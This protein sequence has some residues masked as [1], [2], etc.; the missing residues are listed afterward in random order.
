MRKANNLLAYIAI[1]G[2]VGSVGCSANGVQVPAIPDSVSMEE[3]CKLSNQIRCAGAM[4]C[5]TERANGYANQEACESARLCESSLGLIFSSNE[6]TTGVIR[7]DGVKAAESLKQQAEYT[8]VCGATNLIGNSPSFIVGTKASGA[9]C[10]AKKDDVVS[11][12]TCQPGLTCAVADPEAFSDA[13][14]C[15]AARAVAAGGRSYGEACADS[16]ECR[17]GIC[18]NGV[19]STDTNSSFCVRVADKMLPAN[20]IS[21]LYPTKIRITPK[22]EQSG[23]DEYGDPK[24]VAGNSGT[25][26]RI[27]VHLIIREAYTGVMKRYYG[28][29]DG[30]KT[31]TSVVN[32]SYVENS[33]ASKQ[34]LHIVNKTD[35]G[36]R[37]KLVT[38]EYNSGYGVP[39]DTFNS[40][41]RCDC[42][43]CASSGL[44]CES[45]WIDSD[46]YQRIIYDLDSYN[47]ENNSTS[48]SCSAT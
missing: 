22:H 19:C 16:E 38:I 36:L 13:R 20:T 29:I 23:Y 42:P 35:D 40:A 15:A 44:D 11:N 34:A 46:G 12:Y 6:M 37:I 41:G 33:T 4:G 26:A 10:S 28:Y 5:C 7:Y 21:S 27:Y 17:N 1:L 3:Y 14:T 31:G 8:K 18:D 39:I 2:L 25:N 43:S 9:D 32:I 24:Y 47:D 45:C 48:V 30:V